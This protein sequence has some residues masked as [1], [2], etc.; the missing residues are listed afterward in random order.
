VLLRHLRH[1]RD[2]RPRGVHQ[3]R[4]RAVQRRR[5]LLL[6]VLRRAMGSA[7]ASMRAADALSTRIA[8]VRSSATPTAPAS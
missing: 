3:R 5:G 8:A 7:G 4:P 2:L 1:R 6:R